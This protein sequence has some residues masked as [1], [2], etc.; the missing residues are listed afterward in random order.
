MV[1]PKTTAMVICG[2]DSTSITTMEANVMLSVELS[3]AAYGTTT[4]I[5]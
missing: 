5:D 3:T 4:R 1:E 2:D